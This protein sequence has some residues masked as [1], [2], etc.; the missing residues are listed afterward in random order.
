GAVDSASCFVSLVRQRLTRRI[1]P[2]SNPHRDAPPAVMSAQ[3]THILHCTRRTR[4]PFSRSRSYVRFPF[5]AELAAHCIFR[6]I[7]QR[8]DGRGLVVRR[9]RSTAVHSQQRAL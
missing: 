7:E 5:L 8:N 9:A 4:G 2:V 1:R 3:R 6:R